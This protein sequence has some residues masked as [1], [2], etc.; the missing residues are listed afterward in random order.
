M[1]NYHK[2]EV[3]KSATVLIKQVYILT[4]QYPKSEIYGITSQTRRAAVSI[5]A[6]IA[7]GMGRQYKKDTIQ[8]LHIARGSLYELEALLQIGMTLDLID[9]KDFR[10][11]IHL[12]EDTN[13]LLNGLI[14]Y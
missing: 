9:E 10:D 11:I 5:A 3:W 7:E 8:F 12:T 2:L 14:N 6:N 4:G 13:K 1:R